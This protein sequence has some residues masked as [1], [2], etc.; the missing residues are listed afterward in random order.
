[1]DV[2]ADQLLILGGIG[3]VSFGLGLV[4]AAV[5]M[6]LGHFRLPLL[7]AALGSPV[8]GAATNLAVS[9]LGALAGAGRHARAGRV[10]LLAL[11]VVGLP[12]AA[13]AVGGMILFVQLD[14]LWAHVVVGALLMVLGLRMSH[15]PADPPNPAG[16]PGPLRLVGEVLVGFLLGG[17]AAVSGLMM[18][19]LRMPVL[20]RFCGGDT[21][22]AVGTNMAVGLLTAAVG[23]ASAWAFGGGFDLPA[24]AVVG[25]FTAL[26]S[27]LG[28][29]LTGRLSPAQLKAWLGRLVAVLG[30]V[31]AAEGVWKAARPR[32]LLPGTAA[33]VVLSAADEWLD[34][35][36]RMD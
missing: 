15:R 20:L 11:A 19:G 23:V 21:A 13:G 7:V 35:P 29:G 22:A 30:L 33:A 16:P 6:V 3:V 24:V 28:A 31:M 14:R 1:M 17:L 27:Y 5:G 32:D 9:G 18:N 12:S 8:A 26:G 10:S 2:T 36:D 34:E 4:G 25:P